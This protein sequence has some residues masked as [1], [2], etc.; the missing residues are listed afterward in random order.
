M[1]QSLEFLGIGVQKSASSWLWSRLKQ[2]PEIWLPPR[3]ELHY[4]DRATSYLSPSYLASDSL[5]S[6]LLGRSEHDV[7]FRTKFIGECRSAI[8]GMNWRGLKWLL[9]YY[10]GGRDER[11]YQSLFHDGVGKVK[12]EIT[13]SYSMLNLE[14]VKRIKNL[15]PDLKVIL[16]LRNPIDRAWSQVRFMSKRQRFLGVHNNKEII[17]FIDSQMQSL[18]GDYPKMLETWLSCF[19]SRQ[20]YIGYYDTLLED[21]SR[22][23]SGIFKFLGVDE[24]LSDRIVEKS[25]RVNVS[26]N[27]EIPKE[28]EL[29]LA[30]K[31]LGDLKWLSSKLGGP[32]TKWLIEAE[33]ILCKC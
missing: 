10:L 15:F 5:F 19:E 18:R 16:I 22:F 12:G 2:H 9:R 31:Y 3:K 14:D 24:T 1:G 25:A 11:W 7:I 27:L 29:H 4:F 17:E 20:V 6:R 23:L 21:P 33:E 26:P 28:V 8:R 13:P 32:T 30:N